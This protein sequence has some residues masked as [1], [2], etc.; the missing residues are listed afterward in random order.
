MAAIDFP[1]S[2]VESEPARMPETIPS[3]RVC[4]VRVDAHQ[5]GSATA[6]ILAARAARAPLAV[7]LVNL[8]NPM[9]MKGPVREVYP[10][11]PVAVEIELPNGVAAKQVRLLE[12]NGGPAKWQ[13]TGDR[14]VRVEIPRIAVHEVVAIDI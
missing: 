3:Y 7:H 6:A 10:A 1:R 5:I 2:R 8:T 14:M 13:R 11:G 9:M 4:G 12:G